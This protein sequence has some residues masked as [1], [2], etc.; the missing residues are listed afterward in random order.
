MQAVICPECGREVDSDDLYEISGRKMCDDCAME[1]QNRPQPCD[2]WAVRIATNT[3][4]SLGMQGTEGLTEKQK[5]IYDFIKSRRGATLEELMQQFNLKENEIRK[6]IAILRHCELARAH[7]RGNEIVY[8]PW[9][10]EEV[11]GRS[12]R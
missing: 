5:A 10:F 9:D 4:R 8:V 1:R 12:D 11:I 6:E 3:R 7:K 2:V